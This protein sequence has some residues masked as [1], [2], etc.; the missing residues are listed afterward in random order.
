M[1]HAQRTQAVDG[2]GDLE[3]PRSREVPGMPTRPCKRVE[4]VDPFSVEEGVEAVENL[5]EGFRRKTFSV[6]L[7]RKLLIM[8]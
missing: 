5:F 3:A 2:S 8:S 1:R 6:S 7:Q 4:A